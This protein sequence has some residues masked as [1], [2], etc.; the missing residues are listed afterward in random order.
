MGAAREEE[1]GGGRRRKLREGGWEW[2]GEREGER[3]KRGRRG[4]QQPHASA[5]ARA[6]ASWRKISVRVKRKIHFFV[7]VN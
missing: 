4:E 7:R 1:R 3:W 6:L 2:E 5:R